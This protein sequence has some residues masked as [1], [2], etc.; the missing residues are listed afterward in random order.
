MPWLVTDT[1]EALNTDH[2]HRLYADK[3]KLKASLVGFPA[4]VAADLTPEGAERMLRAIVEEL[5]SG[6]SVEVASQQ[7]RRLTGLR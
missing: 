6:F 7:V 3:S 5:A 1:G 4:T 2:I